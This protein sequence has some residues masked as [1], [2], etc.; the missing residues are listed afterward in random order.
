MHAIRALSILTGVLAAICIFA[1]RPAFADD[2]Q[3]VRAGFKLMPVGFF[4]R[5][6]ALDVPRPPIEPAP[7]AGKTKPKKSKPK[8]K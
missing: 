8:K 7:E 6:P 2:Q 3:L 1:S 4:T 5:N